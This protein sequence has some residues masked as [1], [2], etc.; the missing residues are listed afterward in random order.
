MGSVF[1]FKFLILNDF[2][3]GWR[4]LPAKILGARR[5]DKVIQSSLTSM[6]DFVKPLFQLMLAN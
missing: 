4:S 2:C 3:G 5:Y 1:S 6:Y